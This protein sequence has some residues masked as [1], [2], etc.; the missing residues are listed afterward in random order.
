M[1]LPSVGLLIGSR[2]FY[3]E[4]ITVGC[5]EDPLRYCPE[6]T[7]TRAEMAV[8]LMR[9]KFGSLYSPPGAQGIFADF[10]INYWA[11]D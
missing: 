1:S 10:D 6:E 8:F 9:S 11:A 3:A 4:G 5:S 7:V 2:L